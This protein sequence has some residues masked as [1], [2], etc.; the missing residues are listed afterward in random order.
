MF[1]DRVQICTVLSYELLSQETN[2]DVI[3]L[4]ALKPFIHYVIT[5]SPMKH[6]SF[7]KHGIFSFSREEWLIERIQI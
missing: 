2:I 4:I 7:L 5:V 6:V 3:F 1:E